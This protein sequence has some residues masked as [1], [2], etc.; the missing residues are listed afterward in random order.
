MVPKKMSVITML[1]SSC[2][3]LTE[4]KTCASSNTSMAFIQPH[5]KVEQLL[6]GLNWHEPNL[7]THL[8]FDRTSRPRQGD[9]GPT[10]K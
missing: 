9:T 7:Q 10:L 8:L 5:S 1:T 3:M 4:N 2:I 6:M